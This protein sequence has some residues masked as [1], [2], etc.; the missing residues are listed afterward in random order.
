MSTLQV[1][2]QNSKP[3]SLVTCQGDLV[4]ADALD[5]KSKL[6]QLAYQNKNISIDLMNVS[7]VSL[8]GLNSILMS[9]VWTGAKGNSVRLILPETSKVLTYLEMT[10]MTNEFIIVI[11]TAKN[12]A[13]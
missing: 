6:K 8:T 2:I 12:Y 7:D 1:T 4:G 5:L 9:K 10:K 13:A 11:G 3:I